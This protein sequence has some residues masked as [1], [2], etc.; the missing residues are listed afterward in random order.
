[1][2]N[3]LLLVAIA[4]VPLC[5]F[6][7]LPI[8]GDAQRGAQVFKDQKC[9][10]CHSVSGEG[11]KSAPDL[12]RRTGRAYTPNTMISL[13]WSHSPAMWSAMEKEGIKRPQL[14]E[15]SAADL[16]AFF[17]AARYFDK[18]GDAGRGK[19]LFVSK[20][21]ADCHNLTSSDAGGAKAVVNWQAIADPI[22]L[23]QAMWNHSTEM[24]GA[25]ARKQVSRPVLASQELTDILVYLQNLPQAKNLKAGFAPSS[26]ETGKELFTL[27]GCAA[28]HT[29][30]KSLEDKVPNRSMVDLAA[31]MWNHGPKMK[32]TLPELRSEEMKRLVGYLWSIQ[33]FEA[34]GDT[35]RGKAVFTKKL[36]ASCHDDRASGAPDLAS[37]AGNFNGF[38]MVSSLWSHGGAMLSQMKTKKVGWQ[39][40]TSAEMGDLIAFLNAPR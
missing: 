23:A 12:G 24:S 22:S 31:A 29:G 16:F 28:C 40:F 26:A 35:K 27:K 13:M 2:R 36:C 34:K 1:M 17:A 30:A 14:S 21:C 11:G 10:L 20:R 32:Q 25:M 18:P 39:R 33:Y 15:E 19:A 7:S 5:A 37:K 3:I 8:P 38:S 9:V 4:G 6:A